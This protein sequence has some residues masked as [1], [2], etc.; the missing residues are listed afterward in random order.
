MMLFDPGEFTTSRSMQT[1]FDLLRID[2]LAE[3][4][5]VEKA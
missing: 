3:N 2:S 5:S 4:I 1:G